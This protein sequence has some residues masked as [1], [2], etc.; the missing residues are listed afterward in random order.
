VASSLGVGRREARERAVHLLYEAEQREVVVADVLAAQVLPADEY[1]AEVCA[2]VESERSEIDATIGSHAT[3]W[4][5]ERMATMDRLV[6]EIATYELRHRDDVPTAVVLNEAVE[7]ANS[8]GSDESGG[9]VNGVLSA[10][11]RATRVDDPGE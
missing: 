7:L 8:Y 5:V 6:L 2:G 11:A 4:T 3:G 9:F 10:I 1:T